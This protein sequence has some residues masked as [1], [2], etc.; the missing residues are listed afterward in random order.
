MSKRA[1]LHGTAACDVVIEEQQTKAARCYY[2]ILNYKATVNV[3]VLAEVNNTKLF[4]TGMLA[5]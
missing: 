1:K 2:G 4:H 5:R 3:T